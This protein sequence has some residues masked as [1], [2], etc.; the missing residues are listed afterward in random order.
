MDLAHLH[1]LLNH[2][3]TIGFLVGLG[4]FVL[5]L[6]GKNNDLRRAALVIF[7]GIALLSVPIFISGSGAQEAICQAAPD[8]PCSDAPL[9]VTIQ[10]SGTGYTFAPKVEFSGGQC[11]FPPAA[12]STVRDGQVVG[13]Q[14]TYGGFGCT[15]APSVAITGGGG[16]SAA[17]TAAL[18]RERI[19]VSKAMIEQ[20]ESAAFVALGLMELTGSF[21]WLALWQF[22]RSARFSR[23]MLAVVLLL[24][25]VTF[26]LMANVSNLGGQI[27]HPEVRDQVQAA[28]PLLST[29][30]PFARHVGEIV[31]GGWRW[32][33]PACETLHFIGLCLL[34]GVAAV[35]DLRMLGVTKGISFRAV[36]RLLPWGMLG[37]GVNLVTGML[38][39][40]A[41]P[42]QYVHLGNWL[43]GQNAAFLWKMIFILLAAL[44]VVY[45]T[46]FEEPWQLGP[47]E[48]APLH[49]KLIA[50]V[51]LFLVVGIMF[52]GR[53]LPFLGGSF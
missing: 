17:A 23:S 25:L 45:F 1:L 30:E 44:N 51:S 8:R 41:D 38:F 46:I 24:S 42:F 35:V 37:F 34:F 22:R 7:L 19:L 12:T 9:A 2:F 3:P 39:F 5:G 31:D 26:G 27:R 40:V 43:G 33:F 32:V 18:P 29:G 14:V 49:A 6:A 36:H 4:I 52:W 50:A 53:M 47:G 10:S 13:I 16:S 15:A 21:A 11:S 20:H 48:D 28:A